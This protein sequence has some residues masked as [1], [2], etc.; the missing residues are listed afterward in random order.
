[1]CFSRQ[2]VDFSWEFNK[3]SYIVSMEANVVAT[4]YIWI[5]HVLK[6]E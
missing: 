6:V 4:N 2:V 3:H 5:E 1:M